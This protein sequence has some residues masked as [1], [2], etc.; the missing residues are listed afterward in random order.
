MDLILMLGL[1][2]TTDHLTVANSVCW[3]GYVLTKEDGH[4]MKRALDL[5]VDS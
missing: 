1:N 2:K 5:E 3:Y 4:I